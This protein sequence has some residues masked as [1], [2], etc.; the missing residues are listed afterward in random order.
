MGVT[1]SYLESD[2]FLEDLRNTTVWTRMDKVN[3]GMPYLKGF[4]DIK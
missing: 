2:K 1:A 3:Q 4:R